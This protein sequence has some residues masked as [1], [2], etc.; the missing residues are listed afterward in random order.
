MKK[1]FLVLFI[2]A[3]IFSYSQETTNQITRS[4]FKHD[5]KSDA[6]LLKKQFKY[7]NGEGK[8]VDVTTNVIVSQRDLESS[9]LEKLNDMIDTANTKAKYRVE[10]KYTYIPRDM[11]MYFS[12]EDKRWIVIVEATVENDFGVLKT[13]RGN[14][15]FDN[16]GN[17]L[18]TLFF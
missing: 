2:T 6:Y 1:L 8:L 13:V 10:N 18:E 17:F 15:H 3:G 16:E 12:E 14:V 4:D 7:T 5:L 9:T 11:L